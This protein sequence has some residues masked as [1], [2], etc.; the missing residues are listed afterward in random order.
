[1]SLPPE[2]KPDHIDDDEGVVAEGGYENVPGE[3]IIENCVAGAELFEEARQAV[4]K[5]DDNG[6]KFMEAIT[7]VVAQQTV[8]HF[9]I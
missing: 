4:M 7:Q 5:G 3:Q 8:R 6:S 1:M 9:D 2:F